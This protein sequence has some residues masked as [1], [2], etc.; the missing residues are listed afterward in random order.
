MDDRYMYRE[1]CAASPH[2]ETAEDPESVLVV[3]HTPE[4]DVLLIERADHAGFL[5]I[6]DGLERPYRRTVRRDGRAR[7]GGG[8]WHRDRQRTRA[9][10]VRCSTGIIRIEYEIYPAVAASLC[11]GRDAQHRALVQPASAA[12]RLEVTLAPREHTALVAA[13]SRRRPTRCFSSSNRDAILQLPERTDGLK[14]CK[15]SCASLSV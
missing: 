11:R 4:L 6:G 9:A 3:I 1:A 15:Q 2:A 7:S 13:V 14:Y 8:N 5:A 12:S 10:A